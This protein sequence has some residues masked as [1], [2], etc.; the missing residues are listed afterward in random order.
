M[1]KAVLAVAL[2]MWIAATPVSAQSKPLPSSASMDHDLSAFGV[3]SYTYRAGTGAGLGV[4]YQKTIE[5]EG[6]LKLSDI[7]D[8]IGIEAGMDVVHSR[9]SSLGTR[10][11]SYDEIMPVVGG[12]WNFWLTPQ[13]ALYPKLDLGWRFGWWSDS[14][15]TGTSGYGG[16]FVQ[17]AAGIVYRLERVT[18]RAELGTGLLRGGVAF[19]L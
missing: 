7:R 18:L 9:W 10:S 19:A 17:A 3:L 16:F 6:V 15:A 5:R 13:A 8:D 2:W 12:V 14:K 11:V 4:R 1:D